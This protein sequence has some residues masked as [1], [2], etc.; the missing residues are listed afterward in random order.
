MGCQSRTFR[1]WPLTMYL[2][3]NAFGCAAFLCNAGAKENNYKFFAQLHYIFDI[4]A[5]FLVLS[6][7]VGTLAKK[8]D[9]IGTVA[10]FLL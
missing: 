10:C 4:C 3:V 7:I 2:K 8:W 5:F 6:D 9:L 1:K